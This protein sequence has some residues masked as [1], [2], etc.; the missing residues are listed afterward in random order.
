VF[1]EAGKRGSGPRISMLYKRLG[2]QDHGS[3]YRL[4]LKEA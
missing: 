4:Q 1:F 2:A 3:A